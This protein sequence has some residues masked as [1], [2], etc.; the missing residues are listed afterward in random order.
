MNE[1]RYTAK[2]RTKRH[3]A[4]ISRAYCGLKTTSGGFGKPVTDTVSR[5]RPKGV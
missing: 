5:F 3:I 4:V 2:Y 1:M